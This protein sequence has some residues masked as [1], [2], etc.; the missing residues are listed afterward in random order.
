MDTYSPSNTGKGILRK[1]TRLEKIFPDP[2]Y[3]YWFLSYLFHLL[4]TFIFGSFQFPMNPH[5]LRIHI[6]KLRLSKDKIAHKPPL[7]DHYFLYMI[8]FKTYYLRLGT[9]A[10]IVWLHPVAIYRIKLTP[11]Y[12]PLYIYI[13]LRL[14]PPLDRTT[15]PK[16]QENRNQEGYKIYES[17]KQIIF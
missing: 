4:V 5:K 12:L 3:S 1:E 13:Y 10:D 6:L 7:L 17:T 15:Q 11:S 16:P 9:P 8:Q 14:C 2:V